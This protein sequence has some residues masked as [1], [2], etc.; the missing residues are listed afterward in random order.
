METEEILHILRNPYGKSVSEMR[1]ARIAACDRIEHLE[2]HLGR[3]ANPLPA[4][5]EDAESKGM[6]LDGQMAVS[7]ANSASF[8]KQWAEESLKS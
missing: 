4:M 3:I 6:V 1:E 5:Q 8:L 2:R 7:M